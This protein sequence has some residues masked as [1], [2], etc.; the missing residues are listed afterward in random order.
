MRRIFSR[1]SGIFTFSNRLQ[2][3]KL[4]PA[5]RSCPVTIR[6]ARLHFLCALRVSRD[7]PN[8]RPEGSLGNRKT[9]DSQRF[10]HKKRNACR[11]APYCAIFT[12]RQVRTEDRTE[13]RIAAIR[14]GCSTLQAFCVC[15]RDQ[16]C[17]KRAALQCS[18]WRRRQE[19]LYSQPRSLPLPWQEQ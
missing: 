16:A 10:A 3:S 4:P 13:G 19:L 17:A 18:R 2:I 5:A 11:E 6:P 1:H 7:Y 9:V 8:S 12:R 15:L 14:D